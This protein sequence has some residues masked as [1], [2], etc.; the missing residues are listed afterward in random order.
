LLQRLKN[1]IS[2]REITDPLLQQ[3]ATK[4]I[5]LSDL[6]DG[7]P[8]RALCLR[9]DPAHQS[10]WLNEVKKLEA[11][12]GAP[13]VTQQWPNADRGSSIQYYLE[14]HPDLLRGKKVMHFAPEASLKKWFLKNHSFL[15]LAALSHH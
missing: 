2:K 8:D 9:E 3:A 10:A 1:E 6:S 12:Y 15:N 7:L 13:L 4:A 14:S 5:A 11:A